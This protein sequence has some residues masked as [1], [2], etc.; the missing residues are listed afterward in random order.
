[1]SILSFGQQPVAKN[2][3]I[4]GFIFDNSYFSSIPLPV[5][6]VPIEIIGTKI[7]IVTDNDGK[8]E[9]EAKEG[10]TLMISGPFIKTK[11]ILITNKNC[12]KINLDT[13][14]LDNL[15]HFQ[16][17]KAARQNSRYYRKL[18]KKV[19]EKNEHGFYDCLD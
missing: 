15:I 3:L 18:V 2:R 4:H 19:K 13:V 17:K 7:K 1:M 14:I 16:S 5:S 12:Y 8:F 9:V 11:K 10:D 6:E